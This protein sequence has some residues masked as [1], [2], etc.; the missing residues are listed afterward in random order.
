[1]LEDTSSR[2]LGDQ[3][4]PAI[5]ITIPVSQCAGKNKEK[6]QKLKRLI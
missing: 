6:I 1:M 5:V 3:Y 2:R 4:L